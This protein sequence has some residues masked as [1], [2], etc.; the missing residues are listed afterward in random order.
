MSAGPGARI[1]GLDRPRVARARRPTSSCST[2]SASGRSASTAVPLALRNSWLLGARLTGAVRMTLAGGQVAFEHDRLPRA[3]GRHGLPRRVGRRRRPTRSARP[4]SRPAMS[5]YQEAVTDPS[6]E[7]QLVC[8]TAPMVGN[9]GV[10]PERDE[11]RRP[12]ARAVLMR[13]ARGPEWTD[14]LRERG[15]VALTGIDTRSLVLHLREAGAARRRR[16]RRPA[17]RRGD[18]AGARSSRRCWAARSSR[19]SR[20]TSRTSSRGRPR[21]RRGRRLRRQELRPSPARE[22]RRRGHRLSARR[23]RRHARR[24]RRR[25]P[26]AGP[27]RPRAARGGD[28]TV[29]SCSAARTSSASASATS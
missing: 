1:F 2:S 3:R 4:S 7:D 24:L 6:F 9:Y 20:P 17:G 26:L 22:G 28:A 14:W 16:R 15:I 18:R 8:F 19:A 27:R 12:H 5:G 25:A 21:A 29:G 10:A 23:R 11:S 13:E